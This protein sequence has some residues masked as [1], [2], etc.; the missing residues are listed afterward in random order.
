MSTEKKARPSA[1]QVLILVLFISY[2]L[3]PII[4]TYVFSVATRWDRTILPEG[5][6]LK[7]YQIAAQNP[8][9]FKTL[10]NSLVVSLLVVVP[11]VYWVHARVYAAKPLLDL[12]MILP[13]GIPG[14]V[15][16]LALVQVFNFQPIA[17]SPFLLIAATVVFTMPFMYR[18]VSNNLAAIDITTL[19]EAAQSLGANTFNVLLRVIIPNIFTGILS[20]SLLVFAT[21]FAEFTLARLIV[22]AGFKTFPM[23]LVEYTRIDGTIAA[24]LS[25]IS[26]TIA[27]IVSLLI[28]WVSSKSLDKSHEHLSAR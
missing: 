24:G 7:G 16:A 25:V 27:W 26:F 19:T 14:V 9:F 11:T 18:S 10:Q 20:G 2:M 1:V 6:S 28:L 15:L 4:A 23:L 12:L 8:Y 17:R 5:Y 13:F 22:G 21:V 3:I